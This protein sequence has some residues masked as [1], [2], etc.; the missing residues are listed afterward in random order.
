MARGRKPKDLNSIFHKNSPNYSP[1]IKKNT[2][3]E[4]KRIDKMVKDSGDFWRE[5]RRQGYSERYFEYEART[6][7]ELMGRAIPPEE[8]KALE[9]EYKDCLDNFDVAKNKNSQAQKQGALATKKN[10]QDRLSQIKQNCPDVIQNL[11]YKK[12]TPSH[13][14]RIIF[15]RISQDTNSKLDTFSKQETLRKSLSKLAKATQSKN[16]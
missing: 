16:K 12:I 10:A 7:P 11:K 15:K 6:D 2:P 14:A 9:K 8:L 3:E 13:A 1:G 5:L 4:Q